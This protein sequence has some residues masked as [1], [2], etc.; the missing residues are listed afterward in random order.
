MLDLNQ[1]NTAFLDNPANREAQPLDYAIL[2]I[3]WLYWARTNNVAQLAA[4]D[5]HFLNGLEGV[6]RY[7]DATDPMEA[8]EA[9]TVVRHELAYWRRDLDAGIHPLAQLG[10]VLGGDPGEHLEYRGPVFLL[11]FNEILEGI[12]HEEVV[13]DWDLADENAATTLLSLGTIVLSEIAAAVYWSLK[14]NG[15]HLNTELT[16]LFGPANRQ[17][18]VGQLGNLILAGQVASWE[19]QVSFIPEGDAPTPEWSVNCGQ[20]NVF[21]EC[22]TYQRILVEM[23][24]DERIKDAITTAWNAKR[25]KFT[26]QNSPGVISTDTS[27]IFVSRELGTLLMSDHCHRID[28]PLPD[29]NVR[30]IGVYDLRNDW[31]LLQQES[32]NRQMLGVLASAL[33]SSAAQTAGIQGFMAYQGQQV[34][35]DL[36]NQVF[37]IPKRG[38]LVWRGDPNDPD[39]LQILVA[40]NQPPVA[41]QVAADRQPPVSIFAV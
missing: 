35:V 28:A 3:H 31:E 29:G 12:T 1:P 22:T 27:G 8:E 10:R 33:H 4:I 26:V 15:Q 34:V 20:R 7:F 18:L 36:V 9:A 16:R 14:A 21:V 17:A 37:R 11:T 39:L 19:R 40:L 13:E 41:R 5:A 23:N 2:A 25:G 38:F 30:A 6:L 32:M 24:D